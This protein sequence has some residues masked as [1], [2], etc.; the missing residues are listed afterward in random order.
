MRLWLF[1]TF[2]SS[3]PRRRAVVSLYICRR[4]G[5][6]RGIVSQSF[7]ASLLLVAGLLPVACSGEPWPGGL[8]ANT[9]RPVTHVAGTPDRLPGERAVWLRHGS[10]RTFI[11]LVGGC[12]M[13]LLGLE[14]RV[15][16]RSS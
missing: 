16:R 14:W 4:P 12:G 2:V 5:G 11:L 8:R 9:G 6:L 13:C 10:I 15:R 1:G 7:F 3:W